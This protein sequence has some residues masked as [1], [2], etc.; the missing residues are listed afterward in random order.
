MRFLNKWRR[1]VLERRQKKAITFLKRLKGVLAVKALTDNEK[2]QILELE[3]RN[4]DKKY[5]EMCKTLNKAART[6]M[7]RDITVALVI[8]TSEFKYPPPPYMQMMY[9]DQI[10]G[11]FVYDKDKIGELKRTKVTVFL[12]ENFVVY[13]PKIPKDVTAREDMRMTHITKPF[14][15]LEELDGI[16]GAVFGEPCNESDKVI[17][18]LLYIDTNDQTVGTCIIGF[19]VE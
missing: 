4:E 19:N 2:N 7:E 16:K 11:E 18:K 12:G 6:A 8:Q 14:M 9:R 5:F 17:K 10:V 15:E 1:N 13:L 3:K